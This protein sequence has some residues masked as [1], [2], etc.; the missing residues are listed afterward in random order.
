MTSPTAKPRLR[1]VL[2]DRDPEVEVVACCD[3]GRDAIDAIDRL[4]PDLVLLDVQMPEIDRFAVLA[5]VGP[6]ACRRWCS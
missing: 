3:N 1:A 5:A 6:S 4:A 2:V